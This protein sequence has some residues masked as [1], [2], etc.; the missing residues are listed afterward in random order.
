MGVPAGHRR[1][2]P[3]AVATERGGDETLAVHKRLD[4]RRSCKSAKPREL[5]KLKA[6]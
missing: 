1:A 6:R 3:V 2:A 4:A 5:S